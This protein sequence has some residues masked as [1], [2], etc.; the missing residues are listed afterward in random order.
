MFLPLHC[1]DVEGMEGTDVE[2]IH[3]QDLAVELG[4]ISLCVVTVTTLTRN[5]TEYTM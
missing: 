5:E 3:Q 4:L 2:G 1:T